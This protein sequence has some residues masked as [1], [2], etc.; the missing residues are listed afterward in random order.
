MN[1][2]ELLRQV[3]YLLR[4]NGEPSAEIDFEQPVGR[5]YSQYI[6]DLLQR[7]PMAEGQEARE[8]LK[9]LGMPTGFDAF[10][11]P[12]WQDGSDAFSL[13]Q[14]RQRMTWLFFAADLAEELGEKW[15]QY[16]RSLNYEETP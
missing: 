3:A 6:C 2:P 1:L 13:E 7:Y 14:Q 11:A 15:V 4:N 10:G 16:V 8:Y 9:G 5:G 12:N